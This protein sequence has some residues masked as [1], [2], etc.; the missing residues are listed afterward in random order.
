MVRAWAVRTAEFEERIGRSAVPQDVQQAVLGNGLEPLR[1]DGVEPGEPP[2]DDEH[3]DRGVVAGKQPFP[4]VGRGW[5][6]RAVDCP[7][8]AS[9]PPASGRSSPAWSWTWEVLVAGLVFPPGRRCRC[10]IP[11]RQ[12]A[13]SSELRREPPQF[14]RRR[15]T[16]KKKKKKKKKKPFP[17]NCRLAARLAGAGTWSGLRAR[18]VNPHRGNLL[19]GTVPW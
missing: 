9:R 8:I 14:P 6:R 18:V 2:P 7:P 4:V 1:V 19:A 10:L 11:S 12:S 16:E 3:V 5:R 13:W 15:R 17:T